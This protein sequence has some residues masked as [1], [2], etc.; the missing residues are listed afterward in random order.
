MADPVFVLAPPRSF[1]SVVCAMLGQHPSLVGLPEVNLH[2]TARMDSWWRLCFQ[3]GS[4]LSHGLLRA[5]AEL[6]FGSQDE[7]AVARARWWVEFRRSATTADVYRELA[8]AARPRA[9][10]D[11]SPATVLHPAFLRR[12]QSAFPH[13][14]FLHLVRH[15]RSTCAS[16]HAAPEILAAVGVFSKAVDLG[17]C[18][19]LADP[20]PLWLATHRNIL[21]F[22]EEVPAARWRRV[23]GEDVLMDTDR[24]LRELAAWLDVD[25]GEES[26]DAMR[27]P[28]R[29]PF[30]RFGPPGARFGNDPKFLEN[31]GLRPARARPQ[32]L[33]GPVAWRT[34]GTGLSG[35]VRQ[36]AVSFGYA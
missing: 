10:V 18:A 11:K 35:E 3:T 32:S 1:T 30:A 28:E 24:H 26:L 33:D 7:D 25:A 23:R 6:V 8:D 22:L 19:S 16:I 14:R 36:M 15:P 2:V 13:A 27:H 5:V 29:S 20:E 34:D 31:P 9:L 21:S 4:F 12:A 17:A